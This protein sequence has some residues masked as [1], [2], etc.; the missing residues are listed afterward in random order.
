MDLSLNYIDRETTEINQL[1]HSRPASFQNISFPQTASNYSVSNS[2]K[3]LPSA[4]MLRS[5]QSISNPF[6]NRWAP[7]HPSFIVS[8][9][10]K[11]SPAINQ[12]RPHDPLVQ[13]MRRRNR[14]QRTAAPLAENFMLLLAASRLFYGPGPDQV[15]PFGD[16]DLGVGEL[17]GLG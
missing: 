11:Y 14:P 8:S 15:V 4:S 9:S 10:K 7:Q 1:N 17:G 12:R 2:N 5:Y 13:P 16:L 3:T 6:H